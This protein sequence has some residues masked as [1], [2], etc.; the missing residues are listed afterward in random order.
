MPDINPLAMDPSA[1]FAGPS[2]AT[3]IAIEP[4]NAAAKTDFGLML[5]AHKDIIRERTSL[6]ERLQMIQWLTEDNPA[7][8]LTAADAKRRSWVRSNFVYD[9]RKL[10]INNDRAHQH[11]KKVLTENEL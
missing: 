8:G 6:R 3:M 9:V 1:P 2:S 10:Y 5:D 11:R 7:R 4:F